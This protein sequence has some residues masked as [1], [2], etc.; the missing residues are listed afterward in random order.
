MMYIWVSFDMSL[1]FAVHIDQV[2]MKASKG[3]SSMTVMA[4]ANCE[5]Q[6]LV[7]LYQGLVLS[8]L[9]ILILSNTQIDKL[10]RIQNEAMRIIL[11]FTTDTSYRAMR[12]L[13][14]FPTIQTRINL[15]RARAYVI[16]SADTQ[17]LLHCEIR[18][19]KEID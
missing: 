9:A 7:L 13:L 8:A 14:D 4:A 11:E 15:C 10:E 17:H 19:K 3:L 6:N 5:Q 12:Y 1:T 18:S 16:I 2:V